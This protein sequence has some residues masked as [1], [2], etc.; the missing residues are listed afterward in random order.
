MNFPPRGP[1]PRTSFLL[2]PPRRFL[3]LQHALSSV[4]RIHRRN[5]SGYPRR[6]NASS[7]RPSNLGVSSSCRT[8]PTSR[9]LALLARPARRAGKH[10]LF[11]VV[12]VPEATNPR[13]PRVH[14]SIYANRSTLL[15]RFP[16][17]KNRHSVYLRSRL[18]YK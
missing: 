12:H 8:G 14:S 4:L 18:L 10:F 9:F 11:G 5:T 17:R 15:L 13:C 16:F 2:L 7:P 1:A 6:T 3:A